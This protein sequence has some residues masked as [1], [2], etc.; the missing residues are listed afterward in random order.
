MDHAGKAARSAVFD[1]KV[2]STLQ[3][4]PHSGIVPAKARYVSIQSTR[5]SF[6]ALS[7]NMKGSVI[8][9]MSAGLF[10]LVAL[11]VKLLGQHLHVTQ[12]LFIRQI[13]MTVIV[14]PSILQGFPGVM[15]TGQ[16]HLQIVRI[17]L[18]LGAMLMGF[19]AVIHMPLADA[20]ALGFAKSFFVTIFAVWI[21]HEAVGP[22]RW[23]AVALGF[24]GVIIMLRPGT[25]SFSVYGLMAVASAACAGLVMVLIRLMARQDSA[26]TIL[27]WQA[28]GVGIAVTVPAIYFWRWPTGTEWLLLAAMGIVSFVGQM[29]N[30]YAFKWGEAS[31]LASLD[32]MR[33]IYATILGYL[34]YETLPST[35]TWIGASVIVAASVYSIWREAKKNQQLTR[36]PGGRG[37]TN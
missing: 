32:Y 35:A 4:A 37:F 10:A 13:I 36:S 8:L 34:V 9:L 27:S 20:T 15:R 2:K 14:A 11:L 24:A 12:I 1:H 21:L 33:L 25:E 30:I 26:T 29:T 28:I 22:R 3:P 5:S 7:G 16:A 31:I 23:A 18:A 6:N 19:T 17:A